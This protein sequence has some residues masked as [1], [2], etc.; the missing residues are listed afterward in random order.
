MKEKVTITKIAAEA[1]VSVSTVS[2]VLNNKPDVLPETRKRVL[3]VIDAYQF[4]VNAHAKGIVQQRCNTIGMVISHDVEYVF[5]NQYFTEVMRGIILETQVYG[6]YV[7]SMYCQNLL[8]ALDA[9][10]QQ[11][12][13]GVLLI[14]PTEDHQDAVNQ[15]IS[16]GVPVVSV[17]SFHYGNGIP[18]VELDDYQGA[19]SG[20]DYLLSCGHRKIIHVAGPGKVPSSMARTRAYWDRMR[21]AGITVTP[22]MIYK[23]NG[24][25]GS[26]DLVVQILQSVPDVTA[27]FAG[28]D[29]VAIG[30]INALQS[31]GFRVPEDISVVGFDDVPMSSQ[32][33]P[34][35][36][37]VRQDGDQK[38]RFAVHMLIDW[39]ESGMVPAENKIVQTELIVRDSVRD[40]TAQSL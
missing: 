9:F 21:A 31:N 17:G 8:E 26:S 22:N 13:D 25:V 4:Q 12:I 32:I 39:I 38:G 34:R 27:I 20:V 6:Y 33:S 37:T 23:S 7:L 40:L 11:R 14:S 18:C 5:M 28:S 30:I 10:R 19:S 35:L 1:G 29:Y 16:S 24:M 15:M 2:R 3:S 36:T